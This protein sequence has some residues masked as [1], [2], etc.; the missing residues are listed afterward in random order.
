M[1]GL[2]VIAVSVGVALVVAAVRLLQPTPLE[3]LDAK[4]H[5]FRLTVRG[6]LRTGGEVVIVGIDEASLEAIG[7]W[8]WPRTRLATLVDR[9]TAAN[10]AVIGF[11]VFFDK[12]D[13][14]VDLRALTAAVE[15]DPGRSATD[16]LVALRA[17]L[18]NDGR[19]AEAL[20]ASGRVVL[21]HFFEFG[22]GEAAIPP[23]EAARVPEVSVRT[24][25]GASV[26]SFGPEPTRAHL[27]I[28][29]LAVAAAGAGY[30]NFFPDPDGM[31]RRAPLVI[32]VGEH[33]AS[34]FSIEMLRRYLGGVPAMVTLRPGEVALRVGTVLPPVDAAGELWVNYLGPPKTT[35]AFLSAADVLAGRFDP[36]TVA[37][38]IVIVGF[39][40][41]GLADEIPSPFAARGPGVELHATLIDNM[42]RGQ[43][44][45]QPAW[46]VPA[47]A[48][49]TVVI[50]LLLGVF[51]LPVRGVGGTLVAAAVAI[52]Y[53]WGTQRL[54]VT[55]GLVLGAV[56][57]LGGIF[58]CYLG[59]VVFEAVT[60]GREKRR[61]RHAFRHYLNPEV[62]ELVASDPAHL[63][64][65][66]E[67]REITIFFSDIRGFTSISEHLAPEAL[68]ELLNEYLGAM[69]DI[70]FR[71]AGLLDKYIG[72]AVM[73][74][75][76]A[77][78]A[79]SDHAARCCR[80]ALDM[81]AAL[82]TLRARW[83]DRGV[84]QFE[85]GIGIHTGDAV[86]GNFGSAQ[87][88]NY[89]AM[90]DSVNLASRL[91]GLNKTYG[92]HILVSESTH[93]AIGEEFVCREVDWVRVKGRQQP[94]AV[95]EPLGRRAEDADGRHRRLAEGFGAALA[96][97][98][99]QAWDEA[100]ARL[101]ALARLYPDDEAVGHFVGRCE[102]QRVEAPGR[103]WDGVYIAKT[104]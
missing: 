58:L 23:E 84:P 104:K 60:E 14:S 95:Y 89:T 103:G 15:A 19:L 83:K 24:S 22:A 42:L 75:W 7:R 5:D 4:V 64:L 29:L 46:V 67:R 50:G 72:D 47:E 52:A 41:T 85:I 32:R 16:L 3:L 98:R 13:P 44:L 26:E 39:T 36:A 57:P 93:R 91:E 94:V 81:R 69:T 30:V 76:G 102:A 34:A 87:R 54:F 25:G 71:H 1:R 37:G 51:L 8:P 68:A 66:G 78:V 11:D 53:L 31:Y 82:A 21:A 100:L 33:L 10:A 62:T 86:V 43:S 55:Q 40:A 27:A 28:P 99:A 49:A 73:A 88:F 80:A 77:P 48:G 38:R 97:Y 101:S 65:G 18:G 12:P 61:I 56:Y 74:F 92:T 63:R 59:A 79:V 6:P 96:A 17:Q 90:G 35:F 70:I 20:R 45:R 2:G 9:L